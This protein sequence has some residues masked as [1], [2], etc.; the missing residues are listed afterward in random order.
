MMPFTDPAKDVDVSAQM[1]HWGVVELGLTQASLLPMQL[2][3]I[4]AHSRMACEQR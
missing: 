3:C 1:A 2:A 4:A